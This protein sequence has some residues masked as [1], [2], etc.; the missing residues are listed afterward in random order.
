M[1]KQQALK[2]QEL[3][4]SRVAKEAEL[5][6]WPSRQMPAQYDESL[7][8]VEGPIIAV[9]SPIYARTRI[10]YLWVQL[11]LASMAQQHYRRWRLL[12]IDDA[13]GTFDLDKSLRKLEARGLV[14]DGKQ[15]HVLRS[16][17]RVWEKR[18]AGLDVEDAPLVAN[19]DDDDWHDPR[20]LA[21]AV[22]LMAAAPAASG[23]WKGHHYAYDLIR[24]ARTRVGVCRAGSGHWVFRLAYV[25]SMGIRY[26]QHRRSLSGSDEEFLRNAR[27][28]DRSFTRNLHFPHLNGLMVR[29]RHGA[30]TSQ[31]AMVMIE[32]DVGASWLRKSLGSP[33][34]EIALEIRER[35]RS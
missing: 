20:H 5:Y 35:M 21:M 9:H 16:G 3:R 6:S 34:A 13:R 19:Y 8:A 24:Q 10:G 4:A 15:V 1:P 26:A 32:P 17:K 22:G 28:V 18:N 11:L 33:C 27:K 30:N 31:M 2:N 25:R 29:F 23:S 14:M 7:A 12:L